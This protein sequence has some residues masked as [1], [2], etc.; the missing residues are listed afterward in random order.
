MKIPLNFFQEKKQL[1]NKF[2]SVAVSYE[3][4][5]RFEILMF[6]KEIKDTVFISLAPSLIVTDEEIERV[7]SSLDIIF[8]EGLAKCVNK[9]YKEMFKGFFIK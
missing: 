4:Y 3:M 8:S 1:I 2:T 9:F 6:I 5:Q 7:L